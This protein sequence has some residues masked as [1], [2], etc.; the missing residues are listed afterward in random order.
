MILHVLSE[1]CAGGRLGAEHGLSYL[2][3]HEGT[4]VL[5]DAGHS[6]LYLR[7]A[8]AMGLDP[9][10]EADLVVLSHGH[11]DHGD[12]LIHWPRPADPD[13]PRR[14]PLHTHPAAFM[15][16]YRKA[17]GSPV[18]LG[19]PESELADRFDVRTSREPLLLAPGLWYLGEIPRIHA[20][21]NEATGFV[22][23]QG[24][25][26]P[27]PDDSGLAVDVGGALVVVTGCAH[28]GVCNTLSHAIRVT[29]IE[30]VHG[31]IGGFHLKRRNRR[32]EATLGFLKDLGVEQVLPSHCTALPALA[33]FFKEF[34]GEQVQT[35][36]RFSW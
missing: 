13:R 29:G 20:F 16:R 14:I 19:F 31:V 35:G 25:P 36:K 23:A 32:L 28:A 6:D 15:K 11:W 27:V 18:G 3:E 10:H 24:M 22:D 5:F 1:N 4:T 26:D 17:D 12:G 7:N 8:K 2:L 34:G 33:A 30:K 9:A 21:E